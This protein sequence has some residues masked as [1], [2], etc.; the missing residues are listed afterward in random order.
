MAQDWIVV[1]FGGTSVTGRENWDRIL[2]ILRQK[3]AEGYKVVMVCSAFTTVSD[4]LEKLISLAQV[5][6]DAHDVCEQIIAFHDTQITK[7]L[8]IDDHSVRDFFADLRRLTLGATSIQEVSPRLWARILSA[9]EIL[10]TKVGAEFLKTHRDL[11]THWLDAR[12]V[13]ETKPGIQKNDYLSSSAEYSFS[14]SLLEH[15]NNLNVDIV[16][17]QGFIGR[18]PRG[19]TVLLGRGGSDTSA[20]YFAAKI[21]AK[22]LEIWTDV[23]G[24]FTANPKM[25][26]SAKLLNSLDYDEAQELATS[27]AK[28]LHPRAIPPVR[29]AE[30]PL[31]IYS[32]MAPHL[33]G[34]CIQKVS[35]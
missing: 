31:Y 10:S 3:K 25:I 13:L 19:E 5:G 33:K 17:T 18:N 26:P 28:A 2:K 16:I 6:G 21:K 11:S 22:R 7:E 20:A 35:Q 12:T 32:T 4:M 8:G 9:G 23:P 1:K 14:P 30:I 27:G 29:H 24:M 34:T 15:L